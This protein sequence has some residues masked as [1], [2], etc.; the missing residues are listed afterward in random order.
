M[1]VPTPSGSAAPPAR[2]PGTTPSGLVP[3]PTRQILLRSMLVLV[4]TAVTVL[5]I[6]GW[7]W[8]DTNAREERSAEALEVA[9]VRTAEVL[10]YDSASLDAHLA[11]ART[12]VTG[13]LAARFDDLADQLILTEGREPGSVTR[14]DI[15]RAA[16]VSS[17]PDRVEV[18]LYVDRTTASP[19]LPQPRRTAGQ[20]TV[21]M[22]LVDGRWLISR[23]DPA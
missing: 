8:L 22:T 13:D 3:L 18:L 4:L 12:Q 1:N 7:R 20:L 5:G 23:L 21:T 17:E 16:V 2:V 10:S 15:G 11:A 19:A 6:V 14:A 9:R